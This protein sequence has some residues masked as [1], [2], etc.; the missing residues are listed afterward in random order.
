MKL[1]AFFLGV[2]LFN[3]S[4]T[5]FSQNVTFSGKNVSLKEVFSAVKQ[6]TGYLFW[7]KKTDLALGRPVTIDAHNLPLVSFLDELFKTQPLKYVI[8]SKTIN[9]YPALAGPSERPERPAASVSNSPLPSPVR[10]RVVD[11]DG[12][13]L[14]GASVVIKGSKKSTVTGLDGVFSLN[15][16]SGDLL[17]VTYVGYQPTEY[18]I[19]S[20]ILASADRTSGSGIAF[21]I[22][23]ARS[24]SKLDEIVLVG[25][26]TESRRF[27]VGAVSTVSSAAI[28]NQPVSN[29][30]AALEGLVPGLNITPTSGAP[31]AAIKV[32]VRGQNSLSQIGFGEKP[33]DQPLFIIDG[34]PAAA[35]NIN[36]NS[37]SSFGSGDITTSFAGMSP[38]SSLNPADIESI[39]ILKDI[40][41]TSI[42]GTQG[43]NGVI[44]ITTKKGRAG[45]TRVQATF[46]TAVNSPSRKYKL[47]NLEQYLAYRREA[48]QNDGINLS[49]ASPLAYP[50]LLLFDQNKRTDWADYY[51]SHTA[52]N[53]D[54]HVSLSG[55]SDR[56][57]FLLSPGYTNSGYNFNG[58]FSDKRF[59]LHSNLNYASTDNRLTVQF[60]FDYA[61]ERNYSAASPSLI[62]GILTPPN[63]PD[64]YNADGNPA[65][66]YKG[67]NTSQFVQYPAALKQPSLLNVYNM[68]NS[69]SLGYRIFTGLRC[70][71]NMGYNRILSN[72]D[73]RLPASTINPSNNPTSRASFTN[74]TFETINI[75][76]QLNYQ[77]NFG[78]GTFTALVGGT[79]KKNTISRVQLNGSDYSDEALLGSIASAATITATD[80]YNPYKY[81]GAFARLG[82]THDMK[83]IVQVSGRRDGSSNFG[84]GRQF[85]A[86][87]SVG[88]GWIFSEEKFF[89]GAN[90]LI[91]YG[92]LTASYGS[93]G[94]DATNPYQYQQLF[95]ND[96]SLPNFQGIR[97][98]FVQNPYN[99][100]YGWDTKKSMNAGLD[101]GFINDRILLNVN[102]Y[103]DRT[104]DQL[105]SYTLPSQTG[106]PSVLSNFA[107]TVQN[108]GIEFN[109]TSKNM[110]GGNFTWNTSFNISANRNKLISFPGLAQSSYAAIYTLGESVN[111]EKG[112]GLKGVNPKTGSFEFYKSDGSATTDPVYGIPAQGGDF[113]T[114]ANTAPKFIGGLGNTISY[115]H[116]SL[117]FQFQFQKKQQANYLKNLYLNTR[118]GE[119]Y[120]QPVEILDRWRE[121]GDMATVQKL[122]TR[123]SLPGY[124]FTTSSGAYS[125]GS[126]IRLRTVALSYM[127]PAGLCK[128][129]GITD[130]KF[131]VNGQNLFLLTNFKVGD[132]ELTDIFT[133]PIQRTINFGL[134]INL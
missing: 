31:G 73:Q 25:Y 130:G 11:A 74:N 97:P 68:N 99:P 18:K 132:P 127:L 30:L 92:K 119:M 98:L 107:A 45:K 123:F 128:K 3:V 67:Y 93:V 55:G 46:N 13:P 109:V 10:G 44:L 63:F 71:V 86:F 113:Q 111:I 37:L 118:P 83:Y 5:G 53:T 115:K 56:I 108:Q 129:L 124:Y 104:S 120:N 122:S 131:Y 17:M 125:D 126:Y 134:T 89:R 22:S 100:N 105:I 60:G 34:V 81:V 59:T 41:A 80:S 38:F 121:P 77:R 69:L 117:Y 87:G 33:Y 101:L 12:N 24:L 96:G 42:Y 66:R 78:R 1:P 112:Y 19:T 84:P 110:A 20:A 9:I 88:L 32:Q 2:F 29:P 16:S 43:A 114:I 54:A 40:S 15:V 36:I 76:P 47:M 26:G 72:E 75:E 35:Q 95:A 103:R 90:K 62:S 57:T 51:L 4:A 65:W 52:R 14:V 23:L 48:L 91:S 61:Y 39:T 85:A 94:T 27:G 64:L 58:N 133:F 50:D 28:E 106:F 102:Y 6:Q 7:Y 82:Y 116:V 21:T 49:T 8:E 79:Y 70:N